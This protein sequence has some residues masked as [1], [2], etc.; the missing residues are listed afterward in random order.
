MLGHYAG[1]LGAVEEGYTY[2][3]DTSCR[4]A[5]V[6]AHSKSVTSPALPP[7]PVLTWKLSLTHLH[8]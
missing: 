3:Q 2:E 7:T 5:L 1:H 8:R 4:E 6:F